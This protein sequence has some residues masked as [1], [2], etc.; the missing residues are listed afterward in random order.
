[1]TLATVFSRAQCGL[2]APLVCVEV[3]LANGLPSLSIVGL[4]ETAVKESKDR[5][6]AAVLN[7]GFQF[8]NDRRITVNLAPADLPK[9]GGRFDLAI[10]LGILAASGQV[11]QEKLGAYEFLGELSLGGELRAVRGVL[12][13][14]LRAQDAGREL[15]MPH[16]NGAEAALIRSATNWIAPHLLTVCAALNASADDATWQRPATASL[17]QTMCYPDIADVRGQPQAKR[18]LEVAA[19][20]GHSLLMIGPPGSGKSMPRN[21]CPGC[22]HLYPKQRRSKWPRSL[23]SAHRA[24]IRRCGVFARCGHRIT[25]LPA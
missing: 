23:P 6:R 25:Q 9:D 4:P 5:V 3:H 13:A 1:M 11:R 7:S 19:A 16:L 10:A 24:S 18:A 17:T 21:A 2:D 22:C 20:G 15:V 8:P 12:P 14:A